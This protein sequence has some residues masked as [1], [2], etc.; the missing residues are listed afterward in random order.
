MT[1]GCRPIYIVYIV[2]NGAYKYIYIYIYERS[3]LY[4]TPNVELWKAFGLV[5]ANVSAMKTYSFNQ[6]NEYA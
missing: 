1:P 6:N 3:D 5:A 4:P 2:Y